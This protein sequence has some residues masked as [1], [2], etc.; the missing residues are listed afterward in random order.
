MSILLSEATHEQAMS[1][2][3]KILNNWKRDIVEVTF[4]K[5]GNKRIRRKMKVHFDE[6]FVKKATT[7]K[8]PE[9]V[10]KIKATNKERDNMVVCEMLP[11]GKY[12][13]RTI[14][15]RNVLR[16]RVVKN[17]K[18]SG[19]KSGDDQLQAGDSDKELSE[20]LISEYN[21]NT[22]GDYVIRAL[23]IATGVI[24]ATNER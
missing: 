20:S 22:R 23:A 4:V 11:S 5:K 13:F 8:F 17:P 6:D 21:W 18:T 19:Q 24:D 9:H 1:Y 16:I 2:M 14:P 3:K 7:G 12:R 10:E 15:L